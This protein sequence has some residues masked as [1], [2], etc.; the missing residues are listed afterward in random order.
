M[1]TELELSCRCGHTRL[2][3]QGAPML[4]VEC[5]CNS[6]RQAGA[7]LQAQAEA[8]AVLDAKGA[9]AFVMYRKDRVR[10]LSGIDTLREYR[11]TPTSKTRRVVASCCNTPM[12][13]EFSQGHWLSLY[14]QLWPDDQQPPIQLRTMVSDLPDAG[15][16]LPKDVPN[17][18]S[19]SM[20]FFF[21]LL[22]AWAAMGFRVPAMP[23]I[24]GA[25]DDHR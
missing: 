11:L 12:F 25:L 22:T 20:G 14:R 10:Y 21:K 23:D 1:P 2:A 16:S 9:T 8:P 5:L 19:Q 7:V 24:H 18:R 15:A 6:C 13:L 3:V 4:S 17:Y